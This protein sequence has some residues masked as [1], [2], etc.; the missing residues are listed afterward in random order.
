MPLKPAQI[1]VIIGIILIGL[2]INLL[3]DIILPFVLGFAVAYLLDPLADRLEALGLP[4]ALATATI[5]LVFVASL[6]VA[7]TLGLPVLA[8][9]VSALVAAVP[10]YIQAL[11][12]LIDAQQMGLP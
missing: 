5:T 12:G 2:A 3:G 4:R 9:Q 6:I 10:G 11:Q 7:L 1:V 8:E